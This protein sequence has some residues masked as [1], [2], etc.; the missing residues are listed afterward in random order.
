M[1]TYDPRIS[2]ERLRAYFP[3]L[4]D[5]YAPKK[6]VEAHKI[7][8]AAEI[9][10]LHATGEFED[11]VNAVPQAIIEHQLAVEEAVLN[12]KATPHPSNVERAQARQRI[13]KRELDKASAEEQMAQGNY[14]GAL[15][16]PSIRDEWLNN[17]TKKLETNK[18]ALETALAKLTPLLEEHN[19]LIGLSQYLGEFGNHIIIPGTDDPNPLNAVHKAMNQK[20]WSTTPGNITAGVSNG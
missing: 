14:Y 17:I 13:A 18:P 7:A 19:A 11:A 4:A 20:P 9:A 16:E 1:T 8:D 12:D 15:L 3:E 10:L 6:V 5:K 2:A